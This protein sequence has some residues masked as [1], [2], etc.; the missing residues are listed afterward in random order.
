[1]KKIKKKSMSLHKN[2]GVTLKGNIDGVIMNIKKGP[3]YPLDEYKGPLQE[4]NK[5]KIINDFVK[6]LDQWVEDYRSDT[7]SYVVSTKKF[8]IYIK[9]RV[10]TEFS[11]RKKTRKKGRVKTDCGE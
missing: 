6:T 5:N 9:N 8:L 11:Y 3:K 10:R 2:K 7:G 1:V 4:L